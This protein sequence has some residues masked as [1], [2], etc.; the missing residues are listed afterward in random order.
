MFVTEEAAQHLVG[1][2]NGVQQRSTEAALE[3]VWRVGGGG[4]AGV[5][6]VAQSAELELSCG[7]AGFLPGA[8]GAD[9]APSGDDALGELRRG[10]EKIG[11]G[12][13]LGAI[14]TRD[15]GG[16]GERL[17]G[18]V[19]SAGEVRELVADRGV[20][21]KGVWA[22]GEQQAEAPAHVLEKLEI[23]ACE[24]E[25]GGLERFAPLACVRE[26]VGGGFA[27]MPNSAERGGGERGG[28]AERGVD[29]TEPQRVLQRFAQAIDGN[30]C[31]V[32]ARGAKQPTN[33]TD[34]QPF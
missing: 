31:G 18:V 3:P 8:P 21:R 10:G 30:R 26:R 13:D 14:Q 34:A 22:F 24:R 28:F 33:A 7:G 25:Q 5:D 12:I 23:V 17:R 15:R 1:A 16:V 11:R 19:P 6:R 4:E 2:E 9:V 32:G 29:C 20:G 27:L